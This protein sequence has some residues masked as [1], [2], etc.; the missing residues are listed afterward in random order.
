MDFVN[1]KNL[2]LIAIAVALAVIYVVF[3]SNWFRRETIAISFTSRPSWFA[4]R[5]GPE[6]RTAATRPSFG[7]G[8][9]YQFTEIKVVPV[10]ALQ[11]NA[12][13]PPLWHLVSDAGSDPSDH[14]FYG[15]KIK[16]MDPAVE[17]AQARP[18][19]SGVTYRLLV[20]AGSAHGQRD[21]HIGIDSADT[22][23]NR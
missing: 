6:N 23:T 5:S 19:E 1:R 12:L 4:R 18:L 20:R 21:F 14:F 17:G 22:T 2:L 7:F 16:G 15:Q 8:Q 11:T 3:F 9:R 10:A 13:T